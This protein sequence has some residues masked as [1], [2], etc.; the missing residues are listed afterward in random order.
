[1]E[2]SSTSA[3]RWCSARSSV[4]P[5]YMPGRLRTGS[6]P[7]RTSIEEASYSVGSAPERRSF[8]RLLFCWLGGSMSEPEGWGKANPG[9]VQARFREFDPCDRRLPFGSCAAAAIIGRTVFER[10]ESRAGSPQLFSRYSGQVGRKSD[11]YNLLAE[12]PG[13]IGAT[14]GGCRESEARADAMEIVE[15]CGS[16]SNVSARPFFSGKTP[17]DE[18]P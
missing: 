12:Q 9:S 5:I 17:S 3:T 13:A 18:S 1:M 14:A 8:M 16:R 6:R 15:T 10:P 11:C 7:S 4:P 2:L